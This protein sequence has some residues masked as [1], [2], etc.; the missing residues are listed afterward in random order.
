MNHDE[1]A[2]SLFGKIGAANTPKAYVAA[3]RRLLKK[4]VAQL[5]EVDGTKRR[6]YWI[7]GRSLGWLECRGL[8]DVGAVIDGQVIQLNDVYV[9]LKVDVVVDRHNDKVESGRV[10]KI[11]APHGKRIELDASPGSAPDSEERA[12]IETFIDQVLLAIAGHSLVG[13][14]APKE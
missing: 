3:L 14:T 5:A 8:Q 12:R 6:V 10:A 11:S 4:S 9:E 2:E 13:A 7:D 1:Y